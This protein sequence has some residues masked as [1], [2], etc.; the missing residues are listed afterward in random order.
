MMEHCGLCLGKA[1]FF[2]KVNG[3]KYYRCL[4]CS[5]VFLDP[6]CF[7]DRDYERA[8]YQ[9][10][11]ND[12]NDPGYQKFVEP[13]VRNVQERFS[14]SHKGLDY[15]AGTG[16]VAAKM[17]RDKG[18]SIE[19]YDPFFWNDPQ[20]LKRKYDF[21]VCCEVIEHFNAPAK[22]FERLKSLLNPNGALFCMTDPYSEDTDFKNWYYKN[23]PTHVF[24]YH[25]ESFAFIKRRFKFSKWQSS[26]RLVMFFS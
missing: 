14:L 26:G 16:P 20:L 4:N 5:A 18:Y 23:D 17:L 2:Y 15:G 3:K 21:I 1:V 8:R 24:L 11:N 12:V 19:L 9:E 25:R 22:E 7:L 13:V 10:H 6:A